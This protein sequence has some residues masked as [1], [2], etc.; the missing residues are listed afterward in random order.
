MPLPPQ[1]FSLLVQATCTFSTGQGLPATLA[2]LVGAKPLWDTVH[3]LMGWPI[4]Q[5]ANVDAEFALGV[6]RGQEVLLGSIPQAAT[7]V[8]GQG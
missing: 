4:S 5:K 2:A 6:T 8:T 3:V 7:Q 1:A